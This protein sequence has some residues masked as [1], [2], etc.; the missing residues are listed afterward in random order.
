MKVIV[1]IPK[2]AYK[3]ICEVGSWSSEVEAQRIINV[4]NS[5]LSKRLMGV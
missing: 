2:K 1:D 5:N 4:A 3:E